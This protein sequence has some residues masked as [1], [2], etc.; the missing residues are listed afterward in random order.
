MYR[1][2]IAI[3]PAV[4]TC[5]CVAVLSVGCNVDPVWKMSNRAPKGAADESSTN[6][7]TADPRTVEAEEVDLVERVLANR[8]RYLDGLEELR[9]YYRS[10]GFIRKEEWTAFELDGLTQ[11]RKFRYIDDAEVPTASLR[12][13]ESIAE[14]DALYD[15]GRALMRSGGHG[16][17]A[18]YRQDKMIEA[19]DVFRSIVD[20]YPTSDKIDDA[21]FMLGE[22][23]KEYLPDVEPIAVRW[24]ECAWQWDSSTPHPARFQAAVV[25]DYRLHDRDR[26]LELYHQVL[27]VGKAVR[28]NRWHAERRIRELTRPTDNARLS[29]R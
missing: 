23:H 15:K 9:V 26:A 20:T 24:Y 4:M 29:R 14:A 22:I 7:A 1:K 12:A 19:V 16:V 10:H 3:S 8:Q 5:I 28:S 17:P 27:K 18:V 6:A 21:A 13:T 2:S 25:Y 11:V